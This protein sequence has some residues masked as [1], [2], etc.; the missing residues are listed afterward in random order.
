MQDAHKST[1]VPNFVV[2]SLSPRVVSEFQS[3]ED[4]IQVLR[5]SCTIPIYFSGY[6]AVTVRNTF[7]IDGFFAVERSR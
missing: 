2:S 5:A 1:S 3:R 6:P 4:L 7:G